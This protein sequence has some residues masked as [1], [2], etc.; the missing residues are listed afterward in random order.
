[1]RYLSLLISILVS[2]WVS[3]QANIDS[4]F[5]ASDVVVQ[6]KVLEHNFSW[7][8]DLGTE[9]HEVTIQVE[10]VYK[11][12]RQVEKDGNIYFSTIINTSWHYP[13]GLI[14]TL[15]EP[16]ENPSHIFFLGDAAFTADGQAWE[17]I[18]I[19]KPQNETDSILEKLADNERMSISHITYEKNCDKTCL[20]C[21][22]IEKENWKTLKAHLKSYINTNQDG[23]VG[24]W[25]KWLL[26]HRNVVY[27]LQPEAIL[28]SLPSWGNWG[29]RFKTKNGMKDASVGFRFG[30]MHRFFGLTLGID[31]NETTMTSF[32]LEPDYSEQFINNLKWAWE[33]TVTDTTK[34][35]PY[36]LM[37]AEDRWYLYAYLD[38]W[39]GSAF[40]LHPSV[41]YLWL[42]TVANLK[43]EKAVYHLCL[44]SQHCGYAVRYES[45]RN[46]QELADKR[47]IPYLLKLAEFNSTLDLNQYEEIERSRL[48]NYFQLLSETLNELTNTHVEIVRINTSEQDRLKMGLPVWQSKIKESLEF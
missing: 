27:I 29:I 24:A 19:I 20:L 16:Y 41:E 12:N 21:S 35:T 28:S 2:H 33:A 7:M 13:E 9:H 37:E 44:A 45:L 5:K 30:T 36:P 11:S 15:F 10:V 8:H 42:G 3:A 23:G 6:G 40:N 32:E 47:C 46:L 48:N 38:G 1:M 31:E 25:E 17:E 22:A 43:D 14:E 26:G 4:L 18:G 39:T 34:P